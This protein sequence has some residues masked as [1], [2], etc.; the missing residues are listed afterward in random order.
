MSLRAWLR[1]GPRGTASM[2]TGRSTFG[3][4]RP[5]AIGDRIEVRDVLD[6]TVTIDHNVVDGAPAIRFTADLR[7]LIHTA[8]VPGTSCPSRPRR[9]P[10]TPQ[11]L[12]PQTPKGGSGRSS[13]TGGGDPDRTGTLAWYPFRRRDHRLPLLRWPYLP[14]AR[15]L[16]WHFGTDWWA[17]GEC[18]RYEITTLDVPSVPDSSVPHRRFG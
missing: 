1:S 5:R 12:K 4:K 10:M 17:A 11:D 14:S 2:G 16:G 7:R 8:A 18:F 6:L 13:S 15:R 9:G 3:G